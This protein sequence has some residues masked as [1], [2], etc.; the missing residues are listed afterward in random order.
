MKAFLLLLLIASSP[1]FAMGKHVAVPAGTAVCEKIKKDMGTEP[2]GFR[3]E[4]E[5]SG[6][7]FTRATLPDVG[8][9]WVEPG[10]TF[11]PDLAS[12]P[13]M[14]LADAEAACAKLGGRVPSAD[15]ISRIYN[16][17][18]FKFLPGW[19]KGS[20]FFTDQNSIGFSYYDHGSVLPGG[21]WAAVGS[22][23]AHWEHDCTMYYLPSNQLACVMDPAPSASP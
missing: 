1:A 16:E 17:G 5:R 7:V 11:I 18:G 14:Q 10:G 15:D 23:C 6:A 4:S 13:D 19:P 20:F 9:G 21:A 3:C 12:T 22:G 8:M 2:V